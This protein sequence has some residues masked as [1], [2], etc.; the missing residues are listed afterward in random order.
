MSNNILRISEM[1]VS[2]IW[3]TLSM[4]A[5][6]TSCATSLVNLQTDARKPDAG[7]AIVVG[8]FLIEPVPE[9]RNP[10]DNYWLSI[11]KSP[12]PRKEYTFSL[13]PNKEEDVLIQLPA[14][15]YEI[16]A[17]Y[18]GRPGI[19]SRG[20]GRKGGLGLWFE[21]KE[22]EIL[23]IGRLHL[24]ISKEPVG[25]AISRPPHRPIMYTTVAI[26]D[27]LQGA[28]ELLQHEGWSESAIER[29]R[30]SLITTSRSS[31]K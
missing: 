21:I 25:Q 26:E 5:F 17:I 29:L 31:L 11:W 10:A 2:K 9:W 24:I 12:V 22:G 1:R 30:K 14:G 28:V 19:G 6:L 13:Q 23:Y 7:N 8:S 3:L 18:E 15:I 16:A 20:H 27:N 4:V